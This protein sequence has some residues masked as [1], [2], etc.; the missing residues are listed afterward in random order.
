MAIQCDFCSDKS[1][2]ATYI[3]D[4]FIVT[5]FSSIRIVQTSV[6]GWAACALCEKLIDAGDWDTL[7]THSVATFFAKYPDIGVPVRV[8]R[9][10]LHQMYTQLRQQNFRKAR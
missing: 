2:T 10:E 5:A 1:V 8:V 4:D 6:G 3:A 7:L 9:E